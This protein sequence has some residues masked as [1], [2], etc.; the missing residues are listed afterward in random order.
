VHDVCLE[1]VM[2]MRVEV[3]VRCGE[4]VYVCISALE[5]WR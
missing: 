4:G 2:G 5:R 1:S 3:R